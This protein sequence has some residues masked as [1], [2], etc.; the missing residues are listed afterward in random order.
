MTAGIYTFEAGEALGQYVLG[1]FSGGKIVKAGASDADWV[2]PTQAAVASGSPVAVALR[3]TNGPVMLTAAGTFAVGAVL[4][5]ADNG[6]VDD[7][8]TIP[9]GIALTAATTAGD[10]VVAALGDYQNEVVSEG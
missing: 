2:G 9:V 1:K 4:Y 10:F 6:K 5:A 3:S 7:E 8:G